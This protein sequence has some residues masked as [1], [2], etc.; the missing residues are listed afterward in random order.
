MSADA[1]VAIAFAVLCGILG[2][3]WVEIRGLRKS[4]HVLTNR[5]TEL[6][7]K[8]GLLEHRVKRLEE[9]E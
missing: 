5:L 7:G 6:I 2:A 1:L 4:S 8:I 3:I 9:R